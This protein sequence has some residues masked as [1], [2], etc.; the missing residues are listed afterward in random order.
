MESV[1]EDEMISLNAIYSEDTLIKL[2]TNP[3]ICSLKLPSSV[4]ISLRVEIP[5]SYPDVP[6]SLLGTQSV[7][8]N[9][10]KGQGQEVAEVAR[11]V[12]SIVF[13]PGV[14]CLYDL[15][16]ELQS[17]LGLMLRPA[18]DSQSHQISEWGGRAAD[19]PRDIHASS[20]ND[21]HFADLSAVEPPWTLSDV[22]T[23]KK[24]VFVARAAPVSSPAEAKGFVGHL[25]ATDKKIAKATHNMTAW[26]I[27]GANG[28]AYQDCNDDGETAA[29]GRLL[30]LMQLMDVWDAMVVVTR[31]Y[32]GVQ[33]GPDRF[34]IIN[35]VARDALVKAGLVP[36]GGHRRKGDTTSSRSKIGG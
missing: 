31:W 34:R 24:S 29:G 27:Q 25:L 21:G 5:P 4:E 33:L 19:A 20:D 30:H 15:L 14:P 9:L 32:G 16:E 3:I 10:A 2:S 36:D 11:N 12:L 13:E 28:V 35:T 17:R 23:E 8:N 7:G 6:P 22:V 1:L 26:R 18:S